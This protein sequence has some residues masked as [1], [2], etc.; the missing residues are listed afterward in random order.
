[1]TAPKR[2]API[3]CPVRG[4]GRRPRWNV[5]HELEC[6]RGRFRNPL[7]TIRIPAPTRAAA[8]AAWREAFGGKK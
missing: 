2:P 5:F 8:E 6:W 4:C 1:M 3:V 7:H